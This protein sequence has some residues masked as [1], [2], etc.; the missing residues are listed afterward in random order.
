MKKAI[1]IGVGAERGLGAQLAKRFT[2]EGL[3]V[4]IAGRTLSRLEALA[5]EIEK[6]GGKATAVC[7]DATN[8][9]QVIKLFEKAG[10]H[11]E[12]A[13]Y[14][15]GN[16][17]PGKI[18]DMDAD[19]F[20]KS[21]KSCCFGGFLFGRESV[22]RMVPSG[23]GTLLFTGAS[24]S[25]RG[26]PNFGAFN[27]AKAGLRTLAQALAKEYGP[28]GI[29]VGHVVIDG[30][31][32]GDKIFNHMPELAKKLGAEGM[33]NIEGIVDGYV[34]LYNQSAQAWTF[35]IDLRTSIEKW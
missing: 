20:E 34:H 16:N 3:H 1:I 4:F 18:I 24:A 5:A 6:E 11:L 28:Q 21:W 23:G 12:L 14:N 7:A 35:E 32:A 31:I 22:R 19:Y 9:E 29:H 30:A 25:L 33:I 15:T 10:S 17:F 13:I 8:E 26:R 2:A 27:S